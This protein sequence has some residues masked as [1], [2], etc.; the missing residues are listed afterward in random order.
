MVAK[1]GAVPI[2]VKV[3]KGIHADAIRRIVH[4][5]GGK[6]KVR[7]LLEIIEDR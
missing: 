5:A 1:A 3:R 4:A 2:T 7:Y 6:H